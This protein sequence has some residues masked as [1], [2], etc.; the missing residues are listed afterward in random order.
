MARPKNALLV[1]DEAHVRAFMR[2]LL[3]ELG[4]EECWEAADGASALHLIKQHKPDLVLL[5]INLPGMTGL[6]VL[7]QI[8]QLD[9]DLPVVMA[10]AQSSMSIV[11]EAVRLG[12]SGYLLKHCPKEETL[13]ALRDIVESLSEEPQ[14]DAKP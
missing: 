14:A 5:D 10:T 11:S 2:L 6:Q 3:R 7:G 13:E 4:I 12:A 9:P 8:R 1:D